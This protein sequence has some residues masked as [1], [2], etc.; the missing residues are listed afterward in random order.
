MTVMSTPEGALVAQQAGLEFFALGEAE[1]A[2]GILA[3]E[4]EILGSLEGMDAF[5]QNVKIVA[6]S[7]RIVLRDLP[8]ILKEHRF[9]ALL[10]DDTSPGAIAVARA[11]Q[12]PFGTLAATPPLIQD[13]P[14]VPPFLKNWPC[15]GQGL[16]SWPHRIRNW[17]FHKILFSVMAE[18]IIAQIR[19]YN[20]QHGLQ[21]I[22]QDPRHMGLLQLTQLPECLDFSN[23]DPVAASHFCYTSPWHE[24]H[25]DT[26]LD[27]PFT[28][29]DHS[30]KIVYVS[31]GTTQNGIA[32]IYQRVAQAFRE[33]EDSVQLVMALGRQEGVS[34]I[35]EA[36]DHP[37][38][39]GS[40]VVGYA[41]QLMILQEVDAVVS[42][43]GMNTALEAINCGLPIVAVPLTNDQPGV[44]ARLVQHGVAVMTNSTMA[45]SL[46][47]QQ[48]ISKVLDD[49]SYKQAASVMKAQFQKA[50]ELDAVAELI[51]YTF[52]TGEKLDRAREE[53]QR[54]LQSPKH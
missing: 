20:K 30:R 24:P 25:R 15:S 2:S 34:D 41:P 21:P 4:K 44:A 28:Q 18:P 49:V 40:I 43:C 7:V 47:F 33:L 52:Q 16:A 19:V 37:L 26:S 38:P 17:T 39:K 29:L 42:H 9:D 31:L 35:L 10:V 14:S 13:D 3:A 45:T 50:P 12:I 46:E 22:L 51:E 6:R 48:A 23:R 1:F 36:L 32:L 8:T 11:Y 54:I 27:F 5:Q 53:V